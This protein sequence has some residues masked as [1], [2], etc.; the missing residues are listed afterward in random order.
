M[1]HIIGV[2]TV[3]ICLLSVI[4][5][6]E[7]GHALAA[8][9]FDIQI[10]RISLGFGKTLFSLAL[11]S[12]CKLD[13][14]LWLVGGRVH[15]LNSRIDNV[16]P[17]HYSLCFDKKPIWIRTIVLLSGSLANLLAAILA[18]LF[19]LMLGFKQLPPIIGTITT[20]SHAATAGLLPG[21]RITQVAGHDTYFW[22]D[23][24]MQFI[25]H[26]GQKHVPITVCASK[27]HCRETILDLHIWENKHNDLSIFS[28][29]GITPDTS[30]QHIE[31]IP[32]LPFWKALSSAGS[33][34]M[35]LVFFFMIMIKQIF[36][37]NIPF[38]ALLGPFKLFETIIDSFFQ[39][40]A[41]FLY[42]MAN[43]NLAMALINVLPIPGLDGGA[44]IYGLIEKAR[45]KPM[46]IALEILIY[47]LF[48]ILFSLVLFQLIMNDLRYYV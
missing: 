19:M 23:V 38:A 36:T 25:M 16:S 30:P 11:K 32:G 1:N 6:H 9:F 45:G 27:N 22:R 7:Y 12:G 28:A 26:V 39:G 10:Q 21:E 31:I 44:I 14:N 8:R 2:I 34:L 46:S 35:G 17:Q 24:G 13:I 15:L 47:R 37:A 43:F 20:P 41:I 29:I 18:L 33:Q 4:G 3:I 5:I 42:F 48:F 40:L